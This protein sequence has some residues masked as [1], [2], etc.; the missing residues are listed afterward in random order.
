MLDAIVLRSLPPICRE[1]QMNYVI[2]Q[3]SLAL[4]IVIDHL[5]DGSR[6]I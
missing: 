2:L 4:Q 3:I 5:T 6:P 1:K